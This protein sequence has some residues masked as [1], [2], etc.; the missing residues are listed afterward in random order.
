MDT[1]TF[2]NS[3]DS[4]QTAVVHTT[5]IRRAGL[6][7]ARQVSGH[8]QPSDRGWKPKHIRTDTRE[9]GF[10]NRALDGGGLLSWL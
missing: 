2:R 4:D 8:Q 7:A 3:A 1:H 9:T 5:E 10:V 6:Q